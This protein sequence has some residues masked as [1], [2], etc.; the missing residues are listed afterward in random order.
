MVAHSR[1]CVFGT[2]GQFED[3]N[4]AVEW[5]NGACDVRVRVRHRALAGTVRHCWHRRTR[6]RTGACV[7]WSCVIPRAHVQTLAGGEYK[8]LSLVKPMT[9]DPPPRE[10]AQSELRCVLCRDVR[11]RC[12]RVHVRVRDVI[13]MRVDTSRCRHR[14][15]HL[16]AVVAAKAPYRLPAPVRTT[17]T[18]TTTTSGQS[19]LTTRQQCQQHRRRCRRRSRC[20][21]ACDRS[22]LR[23][24]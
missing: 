17:I 22:V 14:R 8:P 2:A 18:T 11:C 21:Y 15:R 12:V 6:E 13:A 1:N 5:H 4:A 7:S 16:R 3:F 24:R 10:G 20:V 19:T 23:Q 9:Y